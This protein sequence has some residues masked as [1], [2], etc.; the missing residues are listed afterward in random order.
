MPIKS[1][2]CAGVA[3]IT[4]LM[5]LPSAWRSTGSMKR[6]LMNSTLT[7]VTALIAL[8]S[9]A[10]SRLAASGDSSSASTVAAAPPAGVGAMEIRTHAI[11]FGISNGIPMNARHGARTYA[12]STSAPLGA[13]KRVERGSASAALAALGGATTT[14]CGAGST[15]TRSARS[16]LARAAGTP[17]SSHAPRLSRVTS[18]PI[19]PR[20]LASVVL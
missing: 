8:V 12:V 10:A 3:V 6:C 19:A 16:A 14:R 4:P 18:A 7:W 2:S 11:D 5:R 13:G 20:T 1:C 9:A 15:N 17:A